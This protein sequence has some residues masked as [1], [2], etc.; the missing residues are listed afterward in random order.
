M[1]SSLPALAD[2]M[3]KF[4]DLSGVNSAAYANPYDALI[5]ACNSDPV[6]CIFCS[7]QTG[8]YL[9]SCCSLALFTLYH[10]NASF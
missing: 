7:G 10:Q 6:S 3:N 8:S 2:T 4:E 5:E 1:A 9:S